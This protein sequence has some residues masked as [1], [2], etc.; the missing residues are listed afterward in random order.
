MAERSQNWEARSYWKLGPNFGLDVRNPQLGGDGP[1]IYTFYGITEDKDINLWGLSEGGLFKIYN[2]RSIEIIAGQ[3]NTGGGID[4]VIAGKN[5]DVT[6]TAEKN[7]QVRIRAK[8]IVID[9]D[10]SIA[11]NAGKDV[12]IKAGGR[13]LIQSNQ[14][15]CDALTG[16]LAPKG[17]TFGEM[18]FAGTYVGSNVISSAFNGGSVGDNNCN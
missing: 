7:G 10:E 8:N 9:G 12:K 4:I 18:C 6:I 14:A 3:N 15:S 5:G 16:N 13:F 2:D 1:D 11:I 17:S